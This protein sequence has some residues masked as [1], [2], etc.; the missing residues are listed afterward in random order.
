LTP[1]LRQRAGVDRDEAELAHEV[2]DRPLRRRVVAGDREPPA[3]RLSRRGGVLVEVGEVV[4]GRSDTAISGT[5]STT[6]SADR[7]ASLTL[8]AR[9]PVVLARCSSEAGPRELATVTSW[10]S[11]VNRLASVPPMLPAPMMPILIARL[12]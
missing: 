6:R 5:A 10:P 9:A 8:P 3:G 11:A 12:R 2:H 4:A 1:R 7:T